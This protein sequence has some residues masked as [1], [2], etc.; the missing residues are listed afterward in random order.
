MRVE[1]RKSRTTGPRAR[2]CFIPPSSRRHEIRSITRPRINYELNAG[3]QPRSP[4]IRAHRS[5][6]RSLECASRRN[7]QTRQISRAINSTRR[8]PRSSLFSILSATSENCKIFHS[9]AHIL[10]QK[11]SVG[12]R[13]FVESEVRWG[14]VQAL[15]MSLDHVRGFIRC[16]SRTHR[17]I[18]TAF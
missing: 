13:V 12:S 9:H 6:D 3:E 8:T 2:A 14:D 7:F 17:K 5:R 16:G 1:G 10:T 4:A 15:L 18:Y 11:H